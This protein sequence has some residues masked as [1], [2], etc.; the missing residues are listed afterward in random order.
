MFLWIVSPNV[1]WVFLSWIFLYDKRDYSHDPCLLSTP[2]WKVGWWTMRKG[3]SHNLTSVVTLTKEIW[4][5]SSTNLTHD[6]FQPRNGLIYVNA[7][8]SINYWVV[9]DFQKRWEVGGMII[10]TQKNLANSMHK[11]L[12]FSYKAKYF[13]KWTDGKSIPTHVTKV[14]A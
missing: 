13:S 11:C 2:Q 5:N 1:L 12:N 9:E 6:T 8:N 10:F 3:L 7:S 4:A 14:S